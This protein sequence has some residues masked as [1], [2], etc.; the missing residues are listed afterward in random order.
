[1]IVS[2]NKNP[3][4]LIHNNSPEE[5]SN[6]NIELSSLSD[7]VILDNTVQFIGSISVEQSITINNIN[8]LDI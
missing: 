5:I 7:F 8:Y 4:F 3:S 6:L 2:F 1:M